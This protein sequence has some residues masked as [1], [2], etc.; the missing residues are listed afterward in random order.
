MR[1]LV[2]VVFIMMLSLRILSQLPMGC[3]IP[4]AYVLSSLRSQHVAQ[5]HHPMH[6]S[7]NS[8]CV[9][10]VSVANTVSSLRRLCLSSHCAIIQSQQPVHCQISI[11]HVL[12][13]SLCHS[14]VCVVPVWAAYV[15]SSISK[16]N[17]APVTAT[18]MLLIL[19][20]LCVASVS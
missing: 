7:F 1:C 19:N 4:E 6:S 20:S 13:S 11:V 18:C 10:P 2:S 12:P 17:V 3:P 9:V 5:S 8:Y 16:P 14:S 15:L